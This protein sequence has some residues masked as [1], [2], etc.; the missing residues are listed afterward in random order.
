MRQVEK[1]SHQ[2]CIVPL[3]LTVLLSS[4]SDIEF[5]QLQATTMIIE[6][7][8]HSWDLGPN[9][10]GHLQ[11][12]HI[13]ALVSE[14]ATCLTLCLTYSEVHDILMFRILHVRSAEAIDDHD[15]G[16]MS[17]FFCMIN[18]FRKARIGEAIPRSH[19][20]QR[21]RLWHQLGH[22]LTG[23]CRVILSS[24]LFAVSNLY[25]SLSSTGSRTR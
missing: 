21:L 2:A 15:K 6:Q 24:T 4:F 8:G 1:T 18:L 17:N 12:R 16:D 9:A 5:F 10:T 23:R 25:R 7:A 14:S 22:Y 20:V 11:R 19:E 3:L 13:D